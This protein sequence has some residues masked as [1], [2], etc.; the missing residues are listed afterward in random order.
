MKNS[1]KLKF[2]LSNG[3]I[4]IFV[5]GNVSFGTSL[6]TTISNGNCED[7]YLETHGDFKLGNS[8]KWNGIVFCP[9]GN[10]SLGTS[11]QITGAIWASG[12]ISIGNSSKIYYRVTSLN[13]QS[14]YNGSSEE[15][16]NVIPGEYTLEQNYPNPF[17]PSTTINYQL[18]DNSHVTLQIYDILGNLITT[19]VDK[20]ME[21]GYHNVTWNAGSLASGVYIYRLVSGSFVATKKLLLMK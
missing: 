20:D 1:G 12:E 4:R 19:L 2:D 9:N 6:E 5:S 14:V 8:D 11:C 10:I 3:K 17:N 7:V 15:L 13:K 16:I 18:P 21:A